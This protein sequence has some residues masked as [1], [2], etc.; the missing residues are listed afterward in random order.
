M[1]QGTRN[2]EVEREFSMFNA[3]FSMIKEEWLNNKRSCPES[4]TQDK[5]FYKT[6]YWTNTAS[7]KK[8]F[9]E[10]LGPESETQASKAVISGFPSLNIE[11]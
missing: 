1:E 5:Y 11:H 8:L 7:L 4:E 9:I 10:M 2:D 3:Q 6:G